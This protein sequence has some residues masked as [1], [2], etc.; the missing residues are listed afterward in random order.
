MGGSKNKIF[1]PPHAA[2]RGKILC[3][4]RQCAL[5]RH[6]T[7]TTSECAWNLA[8]HHGLRAACPTGKSSKA[9]AGACSPRLTL[10]L[11]RVLPPFARSGREMSLDAD[12]QSRPHTS[13]LRPQRAHADNSG[14]GARRGFFCVARRAR[15]A[16]GT[17][18]IRPNLTKRG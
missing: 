1:F 17:P 9:T 5:S 15:E 14:P 6:R 3:F 7:T 12:S 16:T 8:R 4:T 11:H 13:T 10:A 2:A 18:A